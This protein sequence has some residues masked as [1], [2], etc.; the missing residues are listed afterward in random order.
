MLDNRLLC[1]ASLV[2][3]GS[4]VADI[5]TDHAYLP[6][7]LVKHGICPSA[8]ASDIRRGPADN[9]RQ[10][11]A[12]AGLSD[13][14]EVRLGDGLAGIAPDEVDDIVIAGMGGETIA[15]IL[16]AAVWVRHA[17]YHLVLQPMTRP[18]QL[19]RYLLTN[20]F[21]LEQ[22]HVIQDGRHLYTVMAAS[23]TGAPPI[24]DEAA[25]YRGALG[26]DGRDFLQKEIDRLHRQEQGARLSGNE[27]EAA[28]L[29]ILIDRLEDSL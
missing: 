18:E 24:T 23:Y 21:A 1:A 13:C 10:N 29:K 26:A 5:G 2:R 27:P 3:P 22:E 6:V 9:A 12:Q 8:I 20:G 25:Y 17:R 16:Q 4:R 15:D 19:R 7:Y 11:V 14:I 28:R